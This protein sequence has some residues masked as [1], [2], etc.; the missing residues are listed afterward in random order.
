MKERLFLAGTIT[1]LLYLLFLLS[2]GSPTPE[3]TYPKL[4]FQKQ[5]QS[6]LLL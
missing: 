3:P 6:Y 1:F 4:T 5:S 2:G